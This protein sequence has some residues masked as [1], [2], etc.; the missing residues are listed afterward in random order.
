MAQRPV[1]CFLS[2]PIHLPTGGQLEL[3]P[4]PV[5]QV[6]VEVPHEPPPCATPGAW[7][8]VGLAGTARTAVGLIL[9]AVPLRAGPPVRQTLP[10]RTEIDILRAPFYVKRPLAKGWRGAVSG[11]RRAG[12]STWVATAVIGSSSSPR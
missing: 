8:V 7:A 5:P 2:P 12:T 6:L 11:C 10:R 4:Q 9:V 1:G 3:L